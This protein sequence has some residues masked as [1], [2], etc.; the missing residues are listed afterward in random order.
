MEP[1]PI[2]Q[3][4]VDEQYVYKPLP[5]SR[6]IRLLRI[7][8][9]PEEPLRCTLEIVI[10]AENPEYDCLS[11]TWGDPL[12][13][14][15]WPPEDRRVIDG[16]PR[17]DMQL[18]HYESPGDGKRIGI[19]ENLYEAL[20]QMCIKKQEGA[21]SG[22]FGYERQERI[23]IDA[24]CINQRNRD[25]QKEQVDMMRDVYGQSKNVV[26]WV[27]SVLFQNLAPSV[28]FDFAKRLR[29]CIMDIN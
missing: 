23:W 6:S 21:A 15:F 5:T 10:L 22:D 29:P 18:N 9:L 8:S 16:Y 27:S 3:I 4:P 2:V 19:A 28:Y 24:V 13:Q 12:Y 11:Y 25:E 17:F 1:R 20:K 14:K 26:V 7:D